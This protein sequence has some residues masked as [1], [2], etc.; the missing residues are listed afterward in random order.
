MCNISWPAGRSCGECG[1][2]A[3][4]AYGMPG[5]DRY[6]CD[7]H[8]PLRYPLGAVVNIPWG[9]HYAKMLG[10]SMMAAAGRPQPQVMM[11]TG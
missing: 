11:T 5:E 10:P 4:V 9:W 6:A 1:V 2:P 7:E 3:T 8:D